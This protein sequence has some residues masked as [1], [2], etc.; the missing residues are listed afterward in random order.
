MVFPLLSSSLSLSSFRAIC[1]ISLGLCSQ[2]L[3]W[4][5]GSVLLAFPPPHVPP[6]C[7]LLPSFFLLLLAPHPFPCS[8]FCV[9]GLPSIVVVLQFL[10]FLS[11]IYTTVFVTPA[12][13]CPFLRP[14]SSLFFRLLSLFS[15]FLLHFSSLCDVFSS[16]SYPL[17][18]WPS[19]FFIRVLGESML[20]IA[21]VSP[22]LSGNQI[23]RE[24]LRFMCACVLSPFLFYSWWL[25]LSCHVLVKE[26]KRKT[27]CRW[28][29]VALAVCVA[30]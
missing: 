14:L 25:S 28:G 19:R 24:C 1:I 27:C 7:F 5:A 9:E 26:E 16:S 4:S 17:L 2:N 15:P 29:C 13:R 12:S 21:I 22:S 18:S 6:H 11:W 8:C 3:L 10:W 20:F 23:K 30:L